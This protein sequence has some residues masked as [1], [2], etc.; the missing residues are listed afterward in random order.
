MAR[1]SWIETRPTHPLRSD[2]LPP[3]GPAKEEQMTPV[4]MTQWLE[5]QM[6]SDESFYSWLA[7]V[8]ADADNFL[9]AFDPKGE[10][11]RDGRLPDELAEALRVVADF[12]VTVE[13]GHA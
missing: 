1:R 10:N 5:G 4:P 3:M 12:E 6:G 8:Q 2:Q 11:V 9:A 13:D 7:Q